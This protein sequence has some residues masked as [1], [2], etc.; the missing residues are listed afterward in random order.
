M[1][2]DHYNFVIKK[3]KGSESSVTTNLIFF[4]FSVTYKLHDPF[5]SRY[6]LSLSGVGFSA[7][8]DLLRR[9]F[10]NRFRNIVGRF[11]YGFFRRFFRFRFSF[12]DDALGSD[13]PRRRLA[14]DIVD[15][16]CRVGVV[17]FRRRHVVSVRDRPR[18]DGVQAVVRSLTGRFGLGFGFLPGGGAFPTAVILLFRARGGAF[19]TA[20]PGGGSASPRGTLSFVS[21]GDIRR[22][23]YNHA[24]ELAIFFLLFSQS[25][26]KFCRGKGD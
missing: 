25:A 5:P 12:G 7:N 3:N 2:N 19:P 1:I 6:I 17:E 13:G 18:P 24:S 4:L 21:H 26:E 22:F 23:R 8:I 15:D 10:R 14:F 9:S 16:F 20:L 11:R